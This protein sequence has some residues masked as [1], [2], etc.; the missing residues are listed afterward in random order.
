ML[1]RAPGPSVAQSPVPMPGQADVLVARR[2]LPGRYN[3]GDGMGES[4]YGAELKVAVR[5]ARRAAAAILERRTNP[6]V[7]IK[8]DGSPVTSADVAA[9]AAIRATVREAFPGDAILSEEGVDDET[10]LSNDRCWIVD[11]L[12]GTS[13]FVAG[14]DDFD[15]FVAFTL[16]GNP[17]V[18]VALQPVTGLLLG[19][20]AGRGAWT[21]VGEGARRRLTVAARTPCRLATKAW[22]GAPG[23]LT[24]LEAV[25]AALDG[26][27]LQPVFSL[28]PRCFLPPDP[29]IDAMI[30]LWTDA[31]LGAWEW[32]IA[33]ADLI[34]REAGGAATDLAG[35]PL[36]YNRAVPRFDAGLIVATDPGL[37]RSLLAA[38]RP[39][40]PSAR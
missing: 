38:L 24:A 29:P 13:Q 40:S 26:R 19:A 23:N 30:G 9:D 12:D 27:L 16:G 14:L 2:T 34:V 22:L 15:T 31:A 37:H 7:S 36:R 1:S 18:A 25:T 39:A 8:P 17:V 11:P 35:A 4:G 6:A 3:P 10:R 5:A 21:Q 33:P 20:V 28:C 32:D